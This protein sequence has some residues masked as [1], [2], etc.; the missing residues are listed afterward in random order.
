MRWRQPS[1]TVAQP[2]RDYTARA[3]AYVR[4]AITGATAI[5]AA[6]YL[7]DPQSGRR[8]RAELRDRSLHTKRRARELLDAAGRDLVHRAR[9]RLAEGV[10]RFE[11][12]PDDATLVAR[13]RSQLGHFS[14][15]PR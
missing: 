2:E 13:V 10:G 4:G 12:D 3:R 6:A 5:G 1:I 11:D 15:H 9:G 7:F 8:R 14:S